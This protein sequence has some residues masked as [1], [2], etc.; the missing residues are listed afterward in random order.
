MDLQ[1]IKKFL[2]T[3]CW[4]MLFASQ[5]ILSTRVIAEEWTYTIR[6]GD[7]L[8][9]LTERHLTSMR[10][11]TRLQQ[12]NGIQNPYVIQPGTRIRIPVSWTQQH[13]HEIKAR[14]VGVHGEVTVRHK[15]TSER[16]PAELG[17]QLFVGDQ[18]QS[19]NDSFVTVEFVDKSRLR[20]QNNSQVRIENMEVFGDYGLI[21]TL[22]DLQDGRTENSV[23]P[24]PE[25]GTRFRIKTPS[26]ISS[27]RGT[28]FRVGTLNEGQST[29]SEV[30]AGSVQVSGENRRIK[31]PAGFGS[32]TMLG[33]PPSKPVTLLPPPDLSET[34]TLYES[35]PLVI[36]LKPL[37]KAQAYRAQI[38]TDQNFKNLWAEFTAAQLPFRDGD[39]PD[40]DY[41][42][43]V[44][45]IDASGIEGQ[46]A[47]IAF[48]LNARPEPP[49]VT[50]PLPGGA[51]DVEE[52]AFHWAIQSE[53]AHY[54]VMISKDESFSDLM[55]FDP[56]VKNN[57]LKLSESLQPGHYF[58]RIASVSA[59]EGAGP[60]SDVMPFRVPYPG[61]ALEETALDETEMTF[62]WRAGAEGQSFHFQL[63]HDEAFN[64]LLYDQHTTATQATVPLPDS[65]SYYLR[66]KTIESDGFEGPWG[67][68]QIIEIPHDIPYWLLLLLLPLFV[69][70]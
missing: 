46:D 43:R 64:D 69:L 61:P 49:F 15:D 47:V 34:P 4:F 28:D 59:E 5:L 8:W 51:V 40:G 18:I 62:A 54:I 38:A 25:S 56:Q 31:V 55:Y 66:I 39:V 19:E 65:G 1:Y 29:S 41:W 21:D 63:A 26:A 32:V 27:V 35:L 57:H 52:Q 14:I 17:M 53:A 44:R 9:N 24:E 3:T 6:P 70:L 20:V 2:K 45:G 16:L 10:Y 22:V 42:L 68:P 48:S 13:L 7:N 33:A 50:A 58:W 67:P 37:E 36:S 23:P 12:L 60:F 11:V 30:L